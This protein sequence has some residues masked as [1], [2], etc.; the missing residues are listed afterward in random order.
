MGGL[1]LTRE[2]A[3]VFILVILGVDHHEGA[4]G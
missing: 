4:G 2:N 1:A 3:L